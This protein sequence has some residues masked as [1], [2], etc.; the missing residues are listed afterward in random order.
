MQ[1]YYL[2]IYGQ[3]KKPSNEPA[4]AI[5]APQSNQIIDSATL[6]HILQMRD[7]KADH[8]INENRS[9][10]EQTRTLMELDRSK[11]QTIHVCTITLRIAVALP[12]DPLDLIIITVH[13]IVTIA[14]ARAVKR[15]EE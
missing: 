10:Q 5:A 1:L 7:D 9:L 4:G 11:D 2:A 3:E 15:R 13:S 8:L 14:A 6:L 12:I